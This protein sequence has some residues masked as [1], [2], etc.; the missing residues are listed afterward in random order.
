MDAVV[1]SNVRPPAVVSQSAAS[2][3]SRDTHRVK[4]GETRLSIAR[5][6]VPGYKVLRWEPADPILYPPLS[7]AMTGTHDTDPLAVWWETL[8]PAE[9][10]RFGSDSLLFDDA[11]RDGARRP[12]PEP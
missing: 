3:V 9:R 1:A 12:A 2:D 8:K 5:L 11:V 4:R 7:V 10:T 6:D